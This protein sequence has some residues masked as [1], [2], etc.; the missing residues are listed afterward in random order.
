MYFV[1]SPQAGEMHLFKNMDIC[2]KDIT[3]L[4][5]KSIFHPQSCRG[6]VHG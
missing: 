3:D 6:E 1:L 4:K 2:M 5:K